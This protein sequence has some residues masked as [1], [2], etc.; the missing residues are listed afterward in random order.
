[1]SRAQ[2][3]FDT[4]RFLELARASYGWSVDRDGEV[5]GLVAGDMGYDGSGIPL[6]TLVADALKATAGTPQC[7]E[8]LTKLTELVDLCGAAFDE[9]GKKSDAAA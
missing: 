2:P 6:G 1:M 5:A 9:A 7:R 4:E 8:I 3:R